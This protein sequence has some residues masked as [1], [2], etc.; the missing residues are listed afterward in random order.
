MLSH[1]YLQLTD[2]QYSLVHVTNLGWDVLD[3]KK[4]VTQKI[5]KKR[6]RLIQTSSQVSKEDNV[7]VC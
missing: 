1:N 5:S 6:E 2:S 3:N 4:H 7:P